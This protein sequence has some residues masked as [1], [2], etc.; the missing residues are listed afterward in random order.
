MT[1][2]LTPDPIAANA[3]ADAA[4]RRLCAGPQAALWQTL[5]QDAQRGWAQSLDEELESYLV[6][7]LM[8]CT[9]DAQLGA[10]ILALDWLDSL[11][12]TGAVR[13]TR[14]RE[15]GDRCLLLAGLYPA[16]AQRRR[17]SLDYFCA[18]GRSAYDTLAAQLRAALGSLYGRL[19]AGFEMLVRVLL[20]VRRLAGTD[21]PLARMALLQ[22]SGLDPLQAASEFPG[23][24]VI[25]GSGRA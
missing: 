4:D 3:E 23:A 17:V 22:R 12:Y 16:Q 13:E 1:E 25:A 8:R 7:T 21:D 15:V 24:I 2:V 9:A 19:A 20:G 11:Q 14:L 6:F 10:R 18:L 5:L